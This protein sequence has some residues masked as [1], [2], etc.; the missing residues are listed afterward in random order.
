MIFYP[1]SVLML[2]NIKDILIIST[3]EDLPKF[4]NLLGNGNNL[5]IKISYTVQDKP[6]GLVDALLVGKK[7]IKKDN[8]CLILGDNLFY[9]EGLP[10]LL[11][12]SIEY[13]KK[14]KS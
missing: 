14:N 2:A 4:K 7:F 9:G 3:K 12:E 6:R 1:L 11:N 13:V 5:G 10:Q 8:V